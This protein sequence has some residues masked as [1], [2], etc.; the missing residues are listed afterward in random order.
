MDVEINSASTRRFYRNVLAN[1]KLPLC[2]QVLR[3]F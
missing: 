2:K 1:E 3:D